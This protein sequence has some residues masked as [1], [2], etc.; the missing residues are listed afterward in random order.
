MIHDHGTELFRPL[1]DEI[2]SAVSAS[3]SLFTGSESVY[4][5]PSTTSSF[6]CEADVSLVMKDSEVRVVEPTEVARQTK[7]IIFLS[8]PHR[9]NQSMMFL[10]QFPM[11]FALTPEAKQLHQS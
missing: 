9:G 1:Q 6:G 7:G 10:Y 8:V 3:E 4:T 11:V 5:G 2:R